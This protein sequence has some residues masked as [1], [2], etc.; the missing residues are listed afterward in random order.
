[1]KLCGSPLLAVRGGPECE[2]TGVPVD[3]VQFKLETACSQDA[4]CNCWRGGR[5]E[6]EAER[7]LSSRLGRGSRSPTWEGRRHSPCVPSAQHPW[8][9]SSTRSSAKD[10][11]GWP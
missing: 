1:M 5:G 11:Q 9:L 4:G 3:F 7:G 8:P 6:E 10:E 2:V